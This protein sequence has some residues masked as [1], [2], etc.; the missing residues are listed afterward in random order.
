MSTNHLGSL[1]HKPDSIT[2][3]A[4]NIS[5]C[6]VSMMRIIRGYAALIISLHQNKYLCV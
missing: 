6:N 2:I 4:E 5:D 3:A 1:H